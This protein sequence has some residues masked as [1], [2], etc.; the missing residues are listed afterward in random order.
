[1]L[2]E[3]QGQTPTTV[4]W[5]PPPTK[6]NVSPVVTT[7][8]TPQ[9]LPRHRCWRRVSSA[10]RRGAAGEAV[11]FASTAHGSSPRLSNQLGTGTSQTRRS[12]RSDGISPSTFQ[13]SDTKIRF[14][15]YIECS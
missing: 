9:T 4:W 6:R 7:A 1:M 8:W 15:R 12:R 5:F 13:H 14:R 2:L 10:D 11:L 3:G